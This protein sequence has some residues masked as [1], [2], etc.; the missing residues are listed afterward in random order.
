[1]DKRI[2]HEH[3]QYYTMRLKGEDEDQSRT[4]I[5]CLD[6]QA[7][8]LA[9][10]QPFTLEVTVYAEDVIHGTSTGLG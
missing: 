10:D 1:M 9:R 7:D 5:S 2:I 3:M 6:R 8:R 4:R